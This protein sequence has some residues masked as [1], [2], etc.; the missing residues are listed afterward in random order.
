MSI[1]TNDRLSLPQAPVVSKDGMLATITKD[2][3]IAHLPEDDGTITVSWQY[4]SN[5]TLIYLDLDVKT[6]RLA[7]KYCPIIEL[8]VTAILAM[9]LTCDN[10]EHDIWVDE[11]TVDDLKPAIKNYLEQLNENAVGRATLYQLKG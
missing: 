1:A 6:E 3:E 10:Y 9:T 8:D 7:S 4:S 2:L 11:L 5:G